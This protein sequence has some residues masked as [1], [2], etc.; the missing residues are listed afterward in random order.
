MAGM[1]GRLPPCAV[2]G[3]NV[4][5]PNMGSY[6][7]PEIPVYSGGPVRKQRRE[8]TTFTK[9]QLEILDELFAKTKY[10]DIF[11][12]E[13]VASKI[14]L[15]ESR[16]Q[17]W[18]KNRRAKY[19]QQKKQQQQAKYK[20]EKEK[21]PPPPP[22]E[23]ARPSAKTAPQQLNNFSFRGVE[24]PQAN[25]DFLKH[26]FQTVSN[27]QRQGNYQ[28]S[29]TDNN[30]LEDLLIALTSVTSAASSQPAQLNEQGLTHAITSTPLASTSVDPSS[31]A[32]RSYFTSAT[33]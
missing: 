13:E 22:A 25:M 9:A 1:F 23:Q 2:N 18:F 17:V 27:F 6:F 14:N 15:P 24:L 28:P 3:I 10:P 11:M 32:Q 4:N 30:N 33:I 26:G 12:R 20:E 5:F 21:F 7:N 29:K 19:R 31:N 8:R 16:V